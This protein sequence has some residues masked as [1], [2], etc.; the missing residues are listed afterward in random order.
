MPFQLPWFL[1]DDVYFLPCSDNIPCS[2]CGI[3]KW[4]NR[5]MAESASRQGVTAGARV[6]SRAILCQIVGVA[7]GSRTE[8]TYS[9]SVS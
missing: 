5:A 6:Q 4:L 7:V 3:G 9:T 1:N 2:L 8:F